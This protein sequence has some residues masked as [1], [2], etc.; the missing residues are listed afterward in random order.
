MYQGAVYKS[1]AR[2]V[3]NATGKMQL[4]G[5]YRRGFSSFVDG[6]PTKAALYGP[7]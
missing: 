6:I 5:V 2:D 3:Q 1:I 7:N 4:V